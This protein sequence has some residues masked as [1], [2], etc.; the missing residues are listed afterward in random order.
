[1]LLNPQ[2]P[3]NHRPAS[4]AAERG[5]A[6]VAPNPAA[7]L[8][9]RASVTYAH[10]PSNLPQQQGPF[11]QDRAAP[12]GSDTALRIAVGPFNTSS[13]TA[14]DMLASGAL[15]PSHCTAASRLLDA[16]HPAAVPR[17]CEPACIS[18]AYRRFSTARVTPFTGFATAYRLGSE[19]P[20]RVALALLRTVSQPRV[21]PCRHAQEYVQ[22]T[23]SPP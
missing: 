2:L 11:C 1:M 15:T 7:Q 13:H 23:E 22:G 19:R 5:V 12:P 4:S 20:L 8:C 14:L 21:L 9:H 3:P 18:G 17:G 10:C 6:G 16:R